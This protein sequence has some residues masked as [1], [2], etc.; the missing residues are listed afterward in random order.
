MRTGI[1]PLVGQFC[2]GALVDATHV[3]TAAHCVT[4]DDRATVARWAA[5]SR[6]FRS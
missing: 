1:A 6:S 3:V 4:G 2:G 5:A